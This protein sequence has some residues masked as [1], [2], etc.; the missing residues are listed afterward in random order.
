MPTGQGVGGR[1]V[2]AWHS[3]V[4]QKCRRSLGVVM[5]CVLIGSSAREGVEGDLSVSARPDGGSGACSQQ[6]N[7]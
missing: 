1:V 6:R 4:S 5:V 7:P 2:F 3:D